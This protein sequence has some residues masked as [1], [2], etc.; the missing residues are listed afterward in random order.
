MADAKARQTLMAGQ[1]PLRSSASPGG[2]DNDASHAQQRYSV[3]TRE[4]AFSKHAVAS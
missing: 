2:R 3:I 4:Q 1:E